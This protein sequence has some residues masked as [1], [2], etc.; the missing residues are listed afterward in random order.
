[1]SQDDDAEAFEQLD[2]DIALKIRK[3]ELARTGFCHWCHEE[4]VGV[5]CSI[6][7]RETHEQR[8]RFRR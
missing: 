3:P 8:E 7:C 4:T 5:Y 2:R 6:E 1:M